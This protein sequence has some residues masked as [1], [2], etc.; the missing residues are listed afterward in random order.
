MKNV[1][2]VGGLYFAVVFAAGFIFG[3]LRVMWMVPRL[4]TQVAELIEAPIMLLVSVVT[5]RWLVRRFREVTAAGYWLGVGLVGLGL[6]ILVEFA[7]VLWLRGLSVAEYFANRNL[8]SSSVYFASLGVFAVLPLL[9]S[10][11]RHGRHDASH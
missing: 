9:L 10:R 5:A 8:V 1:L 6:M 11:L 3:T 4:G 7:V 2:K